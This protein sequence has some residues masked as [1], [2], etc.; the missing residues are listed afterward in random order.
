MTYVVVNIT[1]YLPEVWRILCKISW[2]G[3]W[4]LQVPSGKS[5]I[6]GLCQFHAD[7]QDCFIIINSIMVLHKDLLLWEYWGEVSKHPR[8]E[9]SVSPAY[10]SLF[11]Q[12]LTI[13][14]VFTFQEINIAY[15]DFTQKVDS[16]V[17]DEGL[18]PLLCAHYR[19]YHLNTWS[20]IFIAK[21][22]KSWKRED[23]TFSQ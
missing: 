11:S 3:C 20:H 2:G 22:W 5:N 21:M 19:H 14:M 7:P 17:W 1:H 4:N 8:I 13:T 15:V 18:P 10:Y 12:K 16:S 9:K 23:W 6:C